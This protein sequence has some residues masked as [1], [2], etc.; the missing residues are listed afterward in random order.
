MNENIELCIEGKDCFYNNLDGKLY[1][2]G[3]IVPAYNYGGGTAFNGEVI[4]VLK[5]G[6]A[7]LVKIKKELTNGQTVIV[8]F[9]NR[10]DEGDIEEWVVEPIMPDEDCYIIAPE[11]VAWRW[12]YAMQEILKSNMVKRGNAMIDEAGDTFRLEE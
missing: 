2:E 5:P 10:I 1:Y 9:D 3:D 4:K 12:S 8:E 6:F 7:G 11:P